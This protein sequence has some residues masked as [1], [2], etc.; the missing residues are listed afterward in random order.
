MRTTWMRTTDLRN[1]RR[2]RKARSAR[3]LKSIATRLRV[4]TALAAAKPAQSAEE[5]LRLRHEYLTKQLSALRARVSMLG[6]KTLTFDEESKA[7]YDAVAPTHAD[8]EFDAVL[9]E[10]ESRLPGQGVAERAVSTSSDRDSRFRKT[11]WMPRSKPRSR[12]AAAGRSRTFRCR[13][14]KALSSST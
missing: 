12:D 9:K 7:L 5:I 4:E 1:G 6:G 10:L 3:W 2:T 8:S 13:P 14:G 11:G